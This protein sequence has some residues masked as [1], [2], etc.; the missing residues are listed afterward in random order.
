MLSILIP[1]YNFDIRSLVYQL[2]EQGEKLAVPF[3]IICIEDAS[4]KEF[5]SLNKELQMLSH[6]QYQVLESNMGRSKIRNYLATQSQYDYLLFMDCDSMPVDIHYLQNYVQWLNPSKL[7]YGG[8]CYQKNPPNKQELYFH[9]LYGKNREESN[10]STRQKCAYRSFMTNNFLIPKAIFQKIRFDEQL[11]QY[12]HEDTLFGMELKKRQVTILHLDN[13]LEHIGL[14]VNS[15]FLRKS[16]QAIQNLHFLYSKYKLNKEIRLLNFFIKTKKLYL[17]NFILMLY[18]L[19][20]KTIT[21]NLYSRHPQLKL[22]DFYKI[23]YLIHY[24]QKHKKNNIS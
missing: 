3:E 1:S 2:H 13:P 11:T 21:K 10:A 6:V 12:G 19:L 9:W 5:T 23:G 8:R 16:K 4:S 17:H 20:Q 18:Y 24:N 14:E 22:F 15:A 7:L